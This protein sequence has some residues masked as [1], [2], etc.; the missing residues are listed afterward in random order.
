VAVI[1]DDF[2]TR[3]IG[4]VR[5]LST[6][7]QTVTISVFPFQPHT[8]EV[9]E[10]AADSGMPYLLHM[11]MEPRSK[12]EN[13]GEGAILVSDSDEVIRRKLS[14]AFDNVKGA[15][16][17]NNHMGSRATEDVRVMET[18]MHYLR[19]SGRFFIDSR[20]SNQSA[21][22][23][24]SQRV[25]V[26]CAVMAGYLDVVEERNAIRKRL[27]ELTDSAFGQGPIIIIGHNRPMTIEV[28]EQELPRLA[29]RGVRFV[30]VEEVVK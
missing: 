4:S 6:L 29:E 25:R 5:R 22:F 15:A 2:G 10:F 8:A 18:V 16:G 30:G 19:D 17:M 24:V 13:P 7:G 3:D 26:K 12:T 1:V 9:V 28:L 14:A 11:P 21:A 20:T 23:A 27:Y